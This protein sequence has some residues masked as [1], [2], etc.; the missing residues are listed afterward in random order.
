MI[1]SVLK[2]VDSCGGG[3]GEVCDD[4]WTS[5]VLSAARGIFRFLRA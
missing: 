1:M 4:I 2:F 5:F 3:G